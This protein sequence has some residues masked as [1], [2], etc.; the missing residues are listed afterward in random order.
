MAGAI[1]ELSDA[2]FDS[3]VMTSSVPYLVDFWAPWCKPCLA[4]T[5]VIEEL[6]GEYGDKL[7]VGKINVDDHQEVAQRFGISAIPTLLLLKDGQLV[8]R[9]QGVEKK[10]TLKARI[11]RHV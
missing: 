1:T 2:E 6:A 9:V 7:K 8:E 11:D 10:D 5:P 4:L 3:S